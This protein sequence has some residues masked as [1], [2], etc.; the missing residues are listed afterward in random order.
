MM[1]GDVHVDW[2][3]SMGIFLIATI[4]LFIFLSPADVPEVDK[5]VLLDNLIEKFESSFTWE[6]KTT[7]LFVKVCEGYV[8][9]TGDSP[10]DVDVTIDVALENGWEIGN[11]TYDDGVVFYSWEDWDDGIDIF[12][13]LSM[14]QNLQN[15]EFVITSLVEFNFIYYNDEQGPLKP[16]L[17]A[18]CMGAS[19]DHCEF[20]LGGVETFEGIN[21]GSGAWTDF[22]N[23]A[24]D[25]ELVLIKANWGFPESNDFWI[26]ACNPDEVC[27]VFGNGDA[28]DYFVNYK[29]ANIYQQADVKVKEIKT[30][31]IDKT[32]ERTQVSIIFRVW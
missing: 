23:Q 24:N 13:P 6:V 16:G 20:Q 31:I 8:D 19:L 28:N 17:T 11:V 2:I 29:T 7:P 1:R 5:S 27:N 25:F 9:D 32:G 10:V 18:D 12:C 15:Q 30:F 21:D 3:I 26:L 4:S 14:P 22:N